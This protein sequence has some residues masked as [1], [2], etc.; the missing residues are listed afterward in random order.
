[1]S[2]SY[3]SRPPYRPRRPYLRQSRIPVPKPA[4]QPTEADGRTYDTSAF[5]VGLAKTVGWGL[6]GMGMIY[7]TVEN[8]LLENMPDLAPLVPFAISLLQIGWTAYREASGKNGDPE[9]ANLSLSKD[10]L[11][12]SDLQVVNPRQHPSGAVNA[13]KRFL[14]Y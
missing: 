2:L 6:T 9:E 10:P 1:M 14:S 11:Y 7:L 12:A 13:V 5:K 4:R 3:E 8:K